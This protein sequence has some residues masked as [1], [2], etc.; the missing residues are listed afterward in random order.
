MD[1]NQRAIISSGLC[2]LGPSQVSQRLPQL[3]VTDVAIIHGE[4]REV[5]T[6]LGT[7]IG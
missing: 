2:S 4:I 3:S 6:E 7:D 1:L 5:L